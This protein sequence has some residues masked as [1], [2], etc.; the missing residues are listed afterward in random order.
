MVPQVRVYIV[1]DHELVRYAL[2]AVVESDGDMLVVGE[3]SSGEEALGDIERVTPD[4]VLLD[5]RM[6]GIGG[7][8]TCRRLLESWPGLRVVVLTSYGD[9]DEVFGVL[10]A[11][12]V[13][14]I[15]KDTSPEA[16]LQA[17]R[18]VA[19]GQTVLDSD[20][21]RRVI[22]AGG[23]GPAPFDP[24][25]SERETDV[26][27]LLA[28]GWSNRRIARELW[29]TEPTVKSHV[30]HILRKLKVADRTGAALEAVRLGIVVLPPAG[31][32]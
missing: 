14:Y 12:A 31:S 8:E 4:L 27:T 20:V 1:D 17:L 32:D 19:D 29:I 22:D 15:M 21:A 18:G 13:G 28:R 10:T 30:S 7:V 16:L 5:L 11:G 6:P 23:P 24:G 26:L 3:A 25:L 9:D 2:R